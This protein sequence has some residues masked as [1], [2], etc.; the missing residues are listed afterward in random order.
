[1]INVDV[2]WSAKQVK[3]LGYDDKDLS[4]D[5]GLPFFAYFVTI[6]NP[7]ICYSNGATPGWRQQH[8]KNV[9]VK[10]ISRGFD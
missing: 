9:D 1:L 10:K 5:L 8:A 4:L 6:F 3:I 2:E 7:T